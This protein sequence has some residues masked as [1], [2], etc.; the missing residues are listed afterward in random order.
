[1]KRVGLIGGAFDPPHNGHLE[2]ANVVQAA[3]QLDEIR[4]MPTNI[5]PHKAGSS[6]AA[7]DRVA[8][9]RLAIKDEE[10]FSI[11][12]NELHRDGP[13]YTIDTIQALKD[14]ESETQF[15]F[16]I[17]GDMIDYLPKWKRIDELVQ[18]VH[19]VGVKR[20]TYNGVT[21]Y[22]IQMVEMDEVDVSSS[23]IRKRLT[24]GQSV[25]DLLPKEVLNYIHKH[26][27][28]VNE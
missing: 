8:M 25:A 24:L 27:L 4:F 19:F 12:E 21:S 9:L 14:I 1:M 23:E 11:E 13:S 10:R 20:P 15:Y 5:P 22:P 17:G 6:A 26:S 28:Y 3:L 2:I 16:I 7:K 18:L